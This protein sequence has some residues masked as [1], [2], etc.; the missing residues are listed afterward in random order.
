MEE[1]IPV[2][3]LPQNHALA[4]AIMSYNGRVDFGLL[5]DYDAIPDLDEL[6]GDFA[7]ARD[8]L[9]AAAKAHGNGDG[10][11]GKG[12]GRS[13]PKRKPRATAAS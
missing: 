7:A 6:A 3:F 11:G 4:V 13:A 10:G 1:V 2:A 9:V 12:N 5:A 8:E